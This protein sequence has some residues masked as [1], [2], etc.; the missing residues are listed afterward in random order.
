MYDIHN[1]QQGQVLW[2]HS[3][4]CVWPRLVLDEDVRPLYCES[5]VVTLQAESAQ[6]QCES[7]DNKDSALERAQCKSTRFNKEVQW[8]SECSGGGLRRTNVESTTWQPALPAQKAVDISIFQAP[9]DSSPARARTF[10]GNPGG[11]AG[12]RRRPPQ[13]ART[14]GAG[15]SGGGVGRLRIAIQGSM[16]PAGL[17]RVR[18]AGQC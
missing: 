14:C 10:G 8:E 18:R 17:D 2:V 1:I 6:P 7:A 16:A 4:W 12:A 11:T 13:R 9:T 3:V 5:H 15:R